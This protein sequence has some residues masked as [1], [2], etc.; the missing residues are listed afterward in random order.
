MFIRIGGTS[1]ADHA[2]DLTSS[3]WDTLALK[4]M[5]AAVIDRPTQQ[6]IAGLQSSLHDQPIDTQ[7]RWAEVIG[8]RLAMG[9]SGSACGLCQSVSSLSM[10]LSQTST[11]SCPACGGELR[12]PQD[13]LA[14][15]PL[16]ST[17]DSQTRGLQKNTS[18]SQAL[19]ESFGDLCSIS[20]RVTIIDR[21]GVTD[22]ARAE[23]T[24]TGASGLVRLIKL[25]DAHGVPEAELIVG[26]GMKRKG[27]K[28]NAGDVLL[29]AQQVLNS[30][31]LSMRI[32]L[33][34]LSERDARDDL[35]DRW[36]GFSW[37]GQGQL[38]WSL[39]KGLSQFDGARTASHHAL[40][41]QADGTVANLASQSKSAAQLDAVL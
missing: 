6:F 39:G 8:A 21:Y 24:A 31:H 10:A 37:G 25:A 32:R 7:A 19:T 41:R 38:S 36:V 18:C 27:Q 35:H 40:A 13:F 3:E 30:S 28:L 11:E 2:T 34:V 26:S 16:D 1:G 4:V 15:G 14:P 17:R 20:R 22:A 33:I 29:L 23:S 9:R 5:H 12:V